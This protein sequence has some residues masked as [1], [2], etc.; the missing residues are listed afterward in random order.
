M[1][2]A[3]RSPA[4][5]DEIHALPKVLLHDHLDGGL[6]PATVIDLAR[7][8]GYELPTY[9]PDDLEA[10]FRR[11]ADRKSLPLF[12]ESIGH[13]VGVMQTEDA[14]ARVASE[15]V[16]DLAADGIVYA[17]LRFA[18]E[19]FT[20]RGLTLDEAMAATASGLEDGVRRAS[21]AGRP[22]EVR[23]IVAAM[24]Q[25]TNSLAAAEVALRW[26]DRGVVGFDLAGPEE[27]FLPERYADALTLVRRAGLQLTLHAGEESGLESI[28]QALQFGAERLGHGVRI[29]DDIAQAQ[30]GEWML[31]PLARQV[32][33]RSI[34]LEICTTSNV[35]TGVAP[36]IAAHP[37]GLLR[38]LGFAVTVNTDDRLLSGIT[39]S[40]EFE[41]LSGALDLSLSDIAQMSLDALR[42]AFISAPER[43]ALHESMLSNPAWPAS[44]SIS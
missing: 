28:E 30:S 1:T 10:W 17:E 25:A 39:L 24:R 29:M 22:I 23:M 35:H 20:Q 19:L 38:Q 3:S 15:A 9:D 18:P 40:S 11:W 27:G 2:T 31:G 13:A 32:H 5:L 36:S 44:P 16:E 6:R 7:A 41:T 34:T 21:A 4:T 42:G 12:L 43:R 37:I 33:D 26:R 14:I 8:I